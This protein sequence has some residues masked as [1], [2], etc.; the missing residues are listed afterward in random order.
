VIDELILRRA[1][2]NRR[3]HSDRTA[4]Y[5]AIYE[6]HDDSA[7]ALID[8]GAEYRLPTHGYRPAHWARALNR[9]PVLARLDD[10]PRRA[11]DRR[12]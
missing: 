1:D 2:L 3:D 10:A 7:L 5:W 12:P 8:A 6:G 9:A 4:L 11:T